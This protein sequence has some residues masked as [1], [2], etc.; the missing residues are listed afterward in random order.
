MRCKQSSG[1][2]RAEPEGRGHEIFAAQRFRILLPPPVIITPF[3]PNGVFTLETLRCYA[4]N[5]SRT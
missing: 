1:L 2:F 4:K 3:Y 5:F